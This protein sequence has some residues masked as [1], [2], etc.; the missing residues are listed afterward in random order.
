MMHRVAS[1]LGLV[2]CTGAALGQQGIAPALDACREIIT[3]M[4]DPKDSSSYAALPTTNGMVT[5]AGWSSHVNAWFNYM[6]G[7]G[8]ARYLKSRRAIEEAASRYEEVLVKGEQKVSAAAARPGFDNYLRA[9]NERTGKVLEYVKAYDARG[10]DDVV[11]Y[12][13]L[14]AAQSELRAVREKL[15]AVQREYD[16]FVSDLARANTEAEKKALFT[17]ASQVEGALA[18]AVEALRLTSEFIPLDPVSAVKSTADIAVKLV[19]ALMGPGSGAVGRLDAKLA[20]LD[21]KSEE[22]KRKAFT[23]RISEA[24]NQID[25]A[26]QRLLNAA[27]AIARN[28]LQMFDALQQLASI[29]PAGAQPKYFGALWDYYKASA[30]AGADL[31]EATREYV[32]F[33]VRDRPG[34]TALL[35]VHVQADIAHVRRTNVADPTGRWMDSATDAERRLRGMFIPWRA[36]DVGGAS[37]CLRGLKE[38]QHLRLADESTKF[39]NDKVFN[40]LSKTDYGRIGLTGP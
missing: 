19:P 9:L 26:Q 5:G 23:A 33:L 39:I 38:F 1:C 21:A 8:S 27:R 36:T 11:K 17:S 22:H 40:G 2:L 14:R 28:R 24:S 35:L 29:E 20:E 15:I 32:D 30:V 4:P 10:A 34:E 12:A 31:H 3:D 13:E 37:R 16:A 25:A 7:S 6:R 18:T